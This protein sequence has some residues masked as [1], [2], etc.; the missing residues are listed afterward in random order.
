MPIKLL[1][2]LKKQVSEQGL[3]RKNTFLPTGQ[4]TGD[5]IR[6]INSASNKKLDNL[7][8]RTIFV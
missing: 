6:H 8:C 3:Y 4:K 7:N 1:D 2:I 5:V